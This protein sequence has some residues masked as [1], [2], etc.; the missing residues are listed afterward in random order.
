MNDMTPFSTSL[1]YVDRM[2]IAPEN[3]RSSDDVDPEVIEELAENIQE[4]GLLSPMIGYLMNGDAYITAGGRRLRALR[5]IE[6]QHGPMAGQLYPVKI[7]DKAEAIDAGNAEQLTHVAMSELDELRIYTLAAYAELSDER[8]ARITGRSKLYVA[9]RRAILKLPEPVTQAIFAKEITL[10]QGIGLTYCPDAEMVTAFFERAKHDRYF[11]AQ[12]MRNAIAQTVRPRSQ[13][14]G[15]VLVD[16]QEYEEAGGRLQAD[17]FTHDPTVLDPGVFTSIAMAEARQ[18]VQAEYPLAAF[19]TEKP[20]DLYAY[21]ILTHPG[22]AAITEEERARLDEVYEE[23]S[24]IR[25][26]EE[27]WDEETG[28]LHAE[29]ALQL[30]ALQEEADLLREKART[31]SYPDDLQKMLGVYVWL[32]RGTKGYACKPYALPSDLKPLIE[33]GFVQ[34]PRTVKASASS[35]GGEAPP[36]EEKLSAALSLR[37]AK[38]KAHAVRMDLIRSPDDVIALYVAHITNRLGYT[39]CFSATPDMTALPDPELGCGP[40]EAWAKATALAEE[41]EGRTDVILALTPEQHR[42]ILAHRMLLC[43]TLRHPLVD[44]I[45]PD[46]IRAI[47]TPDATFLKAYSRDQLAAMAAQ[48]H[49]GDYAHHK[50]GA[51]VELVATLAAKETAWCPIGF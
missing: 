48:L 25:D 29:F 14:P 8:L 23:I 24:A 10:D 44:Q 4:H 1:F 49:P 46:K 2:Q 11:T 51:L 40:S 7:M 17:L 43:L 38:I 33:A 12:A 19:V 15:H 32:E 31:R 18:R 27:N 39:V 16:L 3:P 21:D 35:A 6:E 28:E 37:I 20:D 36:E 45:G 13:M 9:Q 47:W 42:Q 30:S 5:L 22:Y 50:K 34:D 41:V 26:E